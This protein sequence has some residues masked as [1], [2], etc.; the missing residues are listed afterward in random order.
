MGG[1]RRNFR[2]PSQGKPPWLFFQ[3]FLA[4]PF[5][6]GPLTGNDGW[7]DL[8]ATP[9]LQVITAGEVTRVASVAGNNHPTK[10]QDNALGSLYLNVGFRLGATADPIGYVRFLNEAGNE[11]LSV[12]FDDS[13]SPDTYIVANIG[14]ESSA[15]LA[16]AYRDNSNHF[17]FVTSHPDGTGE[18]YVDSV[19]K[20]TFAGPFF[21]T[22]NIVRCETGISQGNGTTKIKWDWI[23]AGEVL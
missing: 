12:V 16:N 19:L 21:A 15:F 8:P 9:S 20:G 7:E 2:G 17:V 13:A 10:G 11:I 22:G 4:D 5:P 14:N 23:I 18:V 6:L 3:N 1:C